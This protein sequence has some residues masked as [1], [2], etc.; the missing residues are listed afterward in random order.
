MK[1]TVHCSTHKEKKPEDLKIIGASKKETIVNIV[2]NYI[3]F[4]FNR[5]RFRDHN[6]IH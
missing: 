1:S 3:Q 4:Y 2:V 6:G 5:K